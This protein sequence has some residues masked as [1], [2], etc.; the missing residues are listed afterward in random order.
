MRSMNGAY[1]GRGAEGDAGAI[2]TVEVDERVARGGGGELGAKEG[3]AA[4]AEDG[5]RG[6]V[7]LAGKGGGDAVAERRD[8]VVVG[9]VGRHG[10]S[11]E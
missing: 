9:G 7:G 10:A 3:A 4:G 1:V 6:A 2:L 5:A 8:G 11:S